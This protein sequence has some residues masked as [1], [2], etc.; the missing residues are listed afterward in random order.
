MGKNKTRLVVVTALFTAITAVCTALISV[1]MPPFGYVHFGDAVIM[2]AAALLPT[3]FAAF[4]GAVGGA[5][6]DVITGYY[7]YVPFTLVV[8]LLVSLCFSNKNEKMLCKRNIIG[9]PFMAVAT[10]GGYYITDV[11]LSK[12]FV[13][14]AASVLG[15]V[16]Q[17][18]GSTVIFLIFAFALD[19]FNFKSKLGKM[20]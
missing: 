14:P 5:M 11:I 7:I 18:V 15:N 2:L 1:P 3:P 4:V 13:A 12:S 16:V 8:K 19:R 6:G 17:V 10:I 9:I 20:L